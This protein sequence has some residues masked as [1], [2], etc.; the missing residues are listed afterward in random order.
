MDF[1]VPQFLDIE[2]KIFGPLTFRQFV[3]IAG[4]AG[5]AFVVYSILSQFLPSVISIVIAVPLVGLGLALAFYKINERPLVYTVQ[6]A[7]QY[8]FRGKSYKWKKEPIVAQQTTAILPSSEQNPIESASV[9]GE[10]LRDLAW[11]LDVHASE[12][13]KEKEETIPWH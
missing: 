13:G 2:D 9:H 4:G 12:S 1:Q 6:A 8:A 7:I 10:R 5:A 3:Y 11:S